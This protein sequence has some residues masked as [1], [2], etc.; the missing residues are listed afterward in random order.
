MVPANKKHISNHK[1]EGNVLTIPD[2]IPFEF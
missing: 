1:E 2:D